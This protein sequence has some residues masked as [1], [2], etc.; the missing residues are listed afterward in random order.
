MTATAYAAE[1]LLAAELQAEPEHV[2][3]ADPDGE[4]P[5]E[6]EGQSQVD[7]SAVASWRLRGHTVTVLSILVAVQTAWVTALAYGFY[8]FVL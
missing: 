1:E 7:I 5:H 6:S 2:Q 3:D 4:A 8:R